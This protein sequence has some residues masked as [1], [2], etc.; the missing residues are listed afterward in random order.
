MFSRIRPTFE[1]LIPWRK[2]SDR[3]TELTLADFDLARISPH[4]RM[5]FAAI[6]DRG[7]RVGTSKDLAELQSRFAERARVTDGGLQISMW[8]PG[9][10]IEVLPRR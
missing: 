8:H 2:S 3:V 7:R 1:S 5:T 10:R 6:D 4:L 9:R